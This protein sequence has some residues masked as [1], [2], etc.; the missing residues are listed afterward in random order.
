VSTPCLSASLGRHRL[1]GS[2][3]GAAAEIVAD[4][5][6]P[7][8]NGFQANVNQREFRNT[9]VALIGHTRSQSNRNPPDCDDSANTYDFCTHVFAQTNT[10]GFRS[11]G[12][13]V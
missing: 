7:N 12:R 10:V 8:Q 5:N 13:P 2:F 6:E 3:G 11:A 1:S 9:P 4:F